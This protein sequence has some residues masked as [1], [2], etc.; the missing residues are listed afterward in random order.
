MKNIILIGPPGAGK[1]TQARMLAKKIKL[2]SY[3][4]G[5]ILREQIKLKTKVGKRVEK[6]IAGGDLVN[7]TLMNKIVFN[8]LDKNGPDFILDGY[9]RNIKQTRALVNFFTKNNWS[10]NVFIIK[11]KDKSSIE[12]TSGRRICNCGRVYHVKYN[13]PKHPGICDDCSST[14]K[15]RDDEKPEVVK[16]RLEIYHKDT[17]PLIEYLKSQKKIKIK[18][19]LIDGE[20]SI[21]KI[22]QDILSKL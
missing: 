15:I 5:D 20:R 10:A 9:P 1:G 16:E 4:T 19:H 2:K 6:I 3:S 8:A 17:E 14:L 18:I 13:P 21:K 22:H 11:L 12:R 7:D